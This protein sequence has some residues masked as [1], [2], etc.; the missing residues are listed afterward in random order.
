MVQE[1]R[2]VLG[3]VDARVLV[4]LA[5]FTLIATI[6]LA[7]AQLVKADDDSQSVATWDDL[8]KRYLVFREDSYRMVVPS[9]YLAADQ[10]EEVWGKEGFAGFQDQPDWFW[11]FDSDLLTFS[12][13]SALAQ[14]VKSGTR[15][16]I[17]EDMTKGEL[18]VCS[19]PE[20]DGA[21][22]KEEIAFKSLP[23]PELARGDT[24][25]QYLARELS[26][27]RIVWQVTLKDEAQA[28]AEAEAAALAAPADEDGGMM[29]MMSG[30]TCSE[31]TFT[32]IELSTNTVDVGLCIPDGITNVDIFASTNLMPD[33][34]PWV[35]VATNLPVTTNSVV[36]SW[37]NLEETNV[38]LA[39]GDGTADTDGDGL[40]DAREFYLYGTQ[41][42]AW[43]SDGDGLNDGWEVQYGLNALSPEG[44][45]GAAGDP[46]QDGWTN[47]EEIEG[48]SSPT[49]RLDVPSYFGPGLMIS[50]FVYLPASGSPQWIE[51]FNANPHY[52]PIDISDFRVQRTSGGVF[53]TVFTIPTN[54]LIAPGDT[55]LIVGPGS[56]VTGDLT[57]PIDLEKP[58]DGTNSH[59]AG[60][61]LIK[62]VNAAPWFEDTIDACLYDTPD[63][64]GVEPT[65]FDEY[66]Y[67][68]FA[69]FTFA[70]NSLVRKWPAEDRNVGGLEWRWTNSPTPHRAGEGADSDQDGLTT[71]QEW[72]GSQNP[73]NQ[74]ATDPF[75]ADSDDD[76]LSDLQEVTN[77]PP[78]N[79]LSPDTD[80]DGFPWGV[81]RYTQDN[82]E[83]G[84]G[85]DP[86]NS[87]SDGDGFYDGWELAL[88]L[89]P[90]DTDSDNNGTLDGDEDSDGDGVSNLAEQSANSN[91]AD[92]SQTTGGPYIVTHQHTKPNWSNGDDFGYGGKLTVTFSNLRSNQNVCVL[93][94]EGGYEDEKFQVRWQGAAQWHWTQ[95][96]A[97]ITS[98]T[99]GNGQNNMRLIVT[100]RSPPPH[101]QPANQGADVQ[102]TVLD[103]SIIE[104]K[105]LPL[106]AGKQPGSWV[107]R[108]NPYCFKW[109][110]VHENNSIVPYEQLIEGNVASYPSFGYN[111]SVSQGE[112]E[113]PTSG[114]PTYHPTNMIVPSTMTM[115]D[116]WL[117]GSANCDS[118]K[119]KRSLEVYRDHLERDYQNFGTGI[120]C[121]DIV[122]QTP[123]VFR[124][125]GGTITMPQTWN[126]FGSVWHAYNGTGGGQALD[127]P[128]NGFT[129]ETYTHPINWTDATGDLER[130]DIVAFYGGDTLQHAHTCMGNPS[131][132][133]GANNEPILNIIAC[134]GGGASFSG[135]FTG[136]WHWYV[137]SSQEYYERINIDAQGIFHSST[138]LYL[139]K[140][141][142]YR[143]Q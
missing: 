92:P 114:N 28:Q 12:A 84:A 77:S 53:E 51:L 124:R 45:D 135:T 52:L 26:K 3:R 61:R 130:G 81:T 1:L 123:W 143:K 30:G 113:N 75:D 105:G 140:I 15:L 37:A 95:A 83:A 127:I 116:L 129:V 104:P 137:C 64:Y 36:W 5:L 60:L 10:V 22:P 101:L 13:K 62:P 40:T 66:G 111:W 102:Y 85:T 59:T 20:K 23:W 97:G 108:G 78:T 43:D 88:D 142:V 138:N 115:V 109:Q 125:Y 57:G 73:F 2:R 63:E 103:V 76:G 54:T 31:I 47:F 58:Y 94:E 6:G 55:L 98:A 7:V 126:C 72:T 134:G 50:E 139:N 119:D 91:P 16:V 24:T 74:E 86:L 67:E 110:Y 117:C 42:N 70:S 112:L 32:A 48:G 29:R 4:L 122:L 39:A 128:T 35:L 107:F 118:C 89:D 65:G 49:D 93:L 100:D 96:R 141:K 18:L 121:G 56:G 120:S 9:W 21:E 99:V 71:L 17:Y 19:L 46:D 87:D 38:F 69:P 25:A 136:T 41:M 68:I 11:T 14:Q 131:Q 132:M 33:G 79:P 80:G 8:I 44:D 27:R 90:L 133:Y 34:F 82:Q 106:K